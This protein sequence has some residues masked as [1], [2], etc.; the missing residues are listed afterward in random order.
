MQTYS[1]FLS[2]LRDVKFADVH[3]HSIVQFRKLTLRRTVSIMQFERIRFLR[4][5]GRKLS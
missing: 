4:S 1:S 3:A 2:F 5:A